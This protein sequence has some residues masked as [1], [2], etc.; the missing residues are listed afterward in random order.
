MPK[1]YPIVDEN[2]IIIWYKAKKDID[3]QKDFYRATALW[4]TNSRW[5]ILI[6]QRSSDKRRDANKRFPAVA[7]T[8]E[9]WETYEENILKEMK[10]ELGLVNIPVTLGAKVKH[11]GE[12]RYIGQRFLATL[13][14]GIDE[15]TFD[16]KEISAIKWIS[17]EKLE[18]DVAAHPENYLPDMKKYMEGFNF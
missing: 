9:E 3:Y 1:L 2:D 6:T 12:T 7:G 17:R 5:E 13:D 16:K 15:F 18:K 4:L 10:E 11:E 14:K 8:V